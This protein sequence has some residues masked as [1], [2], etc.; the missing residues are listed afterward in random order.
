MSDLKA[1]IERYVDCYNSMDIDGMLDCVD[2]QVIFENVSNTGNSMRLQGKD[3]LREVAGLGAQAFTYRRQNVVKLICDDA[4]RSAAAEV[5]FRGI[6]ALDLP[7]GTKKGE[8]I[9]LRGVSLFECR[10]DRLTRIAD[11]S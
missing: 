2:E 6:A 10:G 8:S 3:A 4:A 1:L 11:F 5:E 7:N 9:A